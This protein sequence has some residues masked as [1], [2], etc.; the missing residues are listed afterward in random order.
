LSEGVTLGVHIAFSFDKNS[1][2][3]GDV[4]I[5][6][7]A[8][9]TGCDRAIAARFATRGSAVVV[10]DINEAGG[11]ET[12]H[13][14]EQGGGRAAFFRAGVRKNSQVRDLVSFAE[15]TF[16]DVTVLVNNASAL[17]AKTLRIG[18]TP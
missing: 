2:I 8:G 10:S 1:N 9:G 14:I 4:A 17:T 7:G 6:T 15:A 5:V 3:S 18:W 13:L 16:G 12:V 11:H